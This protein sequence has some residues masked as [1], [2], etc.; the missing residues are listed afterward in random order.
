SERVATAD[1]GFVKDLLRQRVA[2]I[3]LP[4]PLGGWSV[5]CRGLGAKLRSMKYCAVFSSHKLATADPAEQ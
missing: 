5:V 2:G 1:S 3:W 4:C